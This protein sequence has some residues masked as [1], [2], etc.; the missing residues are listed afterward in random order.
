[1]KFPIPTKYESAMQTL[2]NPAIEKFQSSIVQPFLPAF[3]F[4]AGVTYD[5]L[6]LSRIDHLT[7]NLLFLL[8]LALLGSLVII[9]GRFQLGLIP[10]QIQMESG[11]PSLF[12]I[13]YALI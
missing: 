9:T 6:T 11:M 5:S 8:Y 13:E 1:M 10:D 12:S 3:F 7:D 4:F 2:V